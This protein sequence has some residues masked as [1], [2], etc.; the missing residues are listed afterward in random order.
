MRWREAPESIRQQV[1]GVEEAL[2][3]IL[4]ERLV[5]LYLHGSLAMGCFHPERS[6]IDLI[7]VSEGGLFPEEARELAGRFLTLSGEPSPLEFHLLS[8]E[9]LATWRFPT[10]FR[11]HYS[12]GW[13]ERYTQA[14]ATGELPPMPET[15]PDL[16]AHLMVLHLRGVVLRGP[17]IAETFP[18][19]AHRDYLTA[20]LADAREAAEQIVT[21]PVSGVLNLCRVWLYATGRQVT[22]KAE[23]GE[24]V[25]A[26]AALAPAHRALIH[27]AL[28]RY[29]GESQH[30][31]FDPEALRSFA[32]EMEQRIAA[33]T[34]R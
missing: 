21:N 14:V 12:E 29:R 20:V 15:D 30:L 19:V 2:A 26:R 1:G 28:A 33:W 9:D 16:A 22:S 25:L 17:E 11:F 18:Q 10:P 3:E 4:G 5:G 6:D 31:A 32:T 8:T 34:K 23:G 24:W 27:L 7:G 13:R